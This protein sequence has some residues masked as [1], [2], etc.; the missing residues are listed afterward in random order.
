[1]KTT[2]QEFVTALGVIALAMAVQAAETGTAPV[3]QKESESAAARA[4]ILIADFEG[5]DYGAWKVEGEAFGKGPAHGTLPGQFPVSGFQGQ[6]LVNSYINGDV[7]TGTLTSPAFTLERKYLNFLIGGGS[8]EGQTCMNLLIADKAV[9]T[10]TGHNNE[11]LDWT[12]WNVGAYAGQTATLQIVDRATGAWGHINIDQIVQSDVR[13]GQRSA[14]LPAERDVANICQGIQREVLRENYVRKEWQPRLAGAGVNLGPWYRIGPF[15]DLPP[16]PDWVRNTESSFAC[17]FD[18]ERDTLAGNGPLLERDY[19]AGNFP[20]TPNAVRLW[21]VHPEWV[22][23][24][25]CDLPRG[26]APSPGES[27]YIYREIRTREPIE[28]LVDFRVRAPEDSWQPGWLQ[29]WPERPAGKFRAHYKCWLNGKPLAVWAGTPDAPPT[30]QVSLEPGVNRFLAKVTNNRHAYGFSFAVSGLHPKPELSGMDGKPSSWFQA[31]PPT[32]APWFR[33]GEEPDAVQDQVESYRHTLAALAGLRFRMT[34]MPGIES[35]VRDQDGSVITIMEKGLETYPVSEQGQHYR[36]RLREL[37]QTVTALLARIVDEDKPLV[38]EVLKTGELLEAHWA[39][40]IRELP[41]ILFLERPRYVHDAMQ[42]T[43]SGAAPSYIRAFDPAKRQVRTLFHDPALKAHDIN[44]SWDGQTVLIGGGGSVHRVGIDGTGFRRVTSGQSPAEL[45]GGGIVFFDDAPG[46]A[47]CKSDEPRRLLFTVDPDGRNRKIVSANLT[48]DNHPQVMNDGRVVFSRWD[49]GVNKGVFNRHAIW[50]QN[51]DGSAL[52]LYFGNTKID[53]FAFYKSR[54]IPNRPELVCIFGGHHE[55]NNGLVGLVWNGNG[56][57]AGDGAG[58]QRITHDTAG[59]ADMGTPEQ[60]QDPYPLNETLFLV[61]YAGD[62]GHKTGIYLL[63]RYGNRKCVFEPEQQ[64]AAVCPQPLCSRERPPVIPANATTPEW[65]PPDLTKR[66]LSDPD[67]TQKGTLLLKDVYQ[68]IEP[69]IERGRAKYLAVMEQVAESRGR[70]G[71]MSLGAHFYV[72]RL[73]GLVPLEEDGSA[74]FEVPALRSLYFHVLDKDG[75][76]LM[77][78][79]SDFYVTPGEQRSCVGCH[80]QRKGIGAPAN[81]GQ[82]PLAMKKDLVR[83]D[84]PNW[85]TRGI[86]EYESVV[87]PVFDKHCVSCHS[88]ENPDGRL[89]LSGDRTTIFNLSYLELAEKRLVHFTHGKGRTYMQLNLDYDGQAPLS[90]GSMLSK[91]TRYVEDPKHIKT[92]LSWDEKLRVFLWIDSNIP[93]YGHYDQYCPTV[94]SEPAI[95]SL[96]DVYQR[97]CAGC[98]NRAGQ[99]DTPAY[100]DPSSI[101]VHTGPSPGQWNI[102]ES[103]LRVRHL[104]LTHPELSAALRAPLAKEAGGWGLCQKDGAPVFADAKDA[105]YGKMRQAL[106]TGVQRKSGLSAQSVSELVGKDQHLGRSE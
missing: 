49:Y 89:N 9:R 94:L 24:Y 76:M 88:G 63:D 61:S 58:F 42:Y 25:L 91:L 71:A 60:F 40:T 29:F 98:H 83:P 87:Q 36:R 15:R 79:G 100:L 1:M 74:R 50:V 48:I 78:Q 34:P 105:D 32:E 43:R 102:A 77:T 81:A 82:S 30:I 26:P 47:P 52:D 37:E 38:E 59:I 44:L 31:Y 11:P 3:V 90:R 54:Q 80:E 64:L 73:V 62:A 23:G 14:G 6:G 55:M 10:A 86:I 85:G 13:S 51:P 103:G 22:D 18:P 41:E 68:G 46:C 93:Y 96:K 35:G 4:D 12:S 7:T 33:E 95:Q 72:N 17:V 56:R 2:T 75:K 45:P 19:P 84:P 28:I 92:T 53:P 21:T 8:H 57:E 104:N 39:A 101:A 66:L 69:E 97:R 27:Q 67:W 5:P 106:E 65:E 70:G 20:A 99:P 16:D